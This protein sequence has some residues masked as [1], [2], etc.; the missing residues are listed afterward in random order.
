MRILGYCWQS[1]PPPDDTLVVSR[2]M[3]G[4]L[5]NKVLG[6]LDVLNVLH[7]VLN[8]LY[9]LVLGLEIALVSF[10]SAQHCR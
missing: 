4:S 7:D 6:I 1:D 10:Y 2:N 5:A 9:A 8:I 3:V